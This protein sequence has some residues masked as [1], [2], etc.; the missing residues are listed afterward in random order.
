MIIMD[1]GGAEFKVLKG[2]EKLLSDRKIGLI[3]MKTSRKISEHFW[4]DSSQEKNTLQSITKYMDQFEY[5]GFIIGRKRLIPINGPC[6][7]K[8]LD[9]CSTEKGDCELDIIFIQ[10]K[11]FGSEILTMI[12]KESIF[13]EEKKEIN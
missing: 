11:G 12:S 6:F 13:E 5:V 8:S 10:D 4:N 2:A 9:V 3:L 1:F 7:E